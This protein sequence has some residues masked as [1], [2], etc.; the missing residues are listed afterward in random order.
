MDGDHSRTG[1]SADDVELELDVLRR[2]TDSPDPA[3][4]PN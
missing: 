1:V 4:T 3:V 2:V